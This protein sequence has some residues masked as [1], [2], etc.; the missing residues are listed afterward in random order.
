MVDAVSVALKDHL[1]VVEGATSQDR[2]VPG[3]DGAPE[4][5]V[6]ICQP[7]DR[8]DAL[9]ALLWI[10]GGGYALGEVDIDDW[11]AKHFVKADECVVVSVEYRLA[12][13]HPFPAPVEDCYAV[14]K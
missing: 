6:R 11:L 2:L 3:P 4:V 9:P 13:E 8:P 5:T 1:P 10:H 12:T 7:T 14:L